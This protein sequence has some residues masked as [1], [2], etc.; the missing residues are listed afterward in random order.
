MDENLKE[1]EAF[2]IRSS[3]HFG[4]SVSAKLDALFS[5]ISAKYDGLRKIQNRL[6]RMKAKCEDFQNQVCVL[7]G[8]PLVLLALS[9][10]LGHDEPL[11]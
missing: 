5:E 1:W 4:R 6:D 2:K 7:L 11:R 8:S 9:G 3:Y 10:S